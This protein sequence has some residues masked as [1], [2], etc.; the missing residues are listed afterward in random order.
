VK[1]N[2]KRY[3]RNA[4]KRIAANLEHLAAAFLSETGIKAED[5]CLRQTVDDQGVISVW[6]QRKDSLANINECHADVETAFSLLYQMHTNWGNFS[7]G[8][9]RQE[10]A[11]LMSKYE[12]QMKGQDVVEQPSEVPSEIQG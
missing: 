3:Q 11:D 7:V 2:F 12:D 4:K 6:F 8:E 9:F 1:S 5:A 10:V